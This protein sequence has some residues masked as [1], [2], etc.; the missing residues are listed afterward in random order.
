MLYSEVI[1]SQL[2]IIVNS[3]QTCWY[4]FVLSCTELWVSSLF[5]CHFCCVKDHYT[6]MATYP[7]HF[8]FNEPNKYLLLYDSAWCVWFI[9]RSCDFLMKAFTCFPGRDYCIVTVPHLVPEFP[10]LQH[11]V[12]SHFCIACNSSSTC[13][14]V[15]FVSI[16]L[17]WIYVQVLFDALFS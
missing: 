14:T 15:L 9:C 5:T 11:F 2:F 4:L 8:H 16:N 1:F 3:L 12:V 13:R 7:L 10:L 17:L 6:G